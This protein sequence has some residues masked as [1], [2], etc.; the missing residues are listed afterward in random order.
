MSGRGILLMLLVM[1]RGYH[2]TLLPFFSLRQT[3][4]V[5]ACLCVIARPL[6][7]ISQD[8]TKQAPTA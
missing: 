2:P 8:G 7:E 4:V 3:S 6:N 5:C 1:I